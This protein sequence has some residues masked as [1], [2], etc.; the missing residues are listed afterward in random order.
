MVLGEV[1]GLPIGARARGRG[2]DRYKVT[3]TFALALASQSGSTVPLF[4]PSTCASSPTPQAVLS[5]LHSLFKS[6][7]LIKLT[8]RRKRDESVC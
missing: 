3:K 5:F 1:L 6:E 2:A 7:G 4:T 8:L